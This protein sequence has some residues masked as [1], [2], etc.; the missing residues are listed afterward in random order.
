MAVT[1]GREVCSKSNIAGH[2]AWLNYNSTEMTDSVRNF[3]KELLHAGKGEA[4][5]FQKNS[6][7]VLYIV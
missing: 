6:K 7:V 2:W 1:R 4:P 3:R 5:S